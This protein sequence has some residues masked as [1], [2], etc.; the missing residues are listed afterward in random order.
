MSPPTWHCAPWAEPTADEGP[1]RLL[2]ADPDAGRP[3]ASGCTPS[4]CRREWQASPGFVPTRRAHFTTREVSTTIRERGR[5]SGFVHP[6][7]S[8]PLESALGIYGWHGGTRG[9][10]GHRCIAYNCGCRWRGSS[11]AT[12]SVCRMRRRRAGTAPLGRAKL[13][14]EGTDQVVSRR[15]ARWPKA[16]RPIG[17]FVSTSGTPAPF[18]TSWS[19]PGTRRDP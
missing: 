4:T 5:F 18:Q 14:L 16:R 10:A 17:R 15:S 11:R 19:R 7:L 8:L 13:M 12:G 6:V 1:G 3:G 2:S 9:K